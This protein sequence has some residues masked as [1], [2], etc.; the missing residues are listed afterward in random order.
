MQLF[1]VST[2]IVATLLFSCLSLTDANAYDPCERCYQQYN[3]CIAAGTPRATCHSRLL[4]CTQ[5]NCN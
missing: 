5:K 1:R 3:A 2:A 4:T